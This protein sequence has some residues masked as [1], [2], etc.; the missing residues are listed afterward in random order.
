MKNMKKWMLAAALV[1]GGLGLGATNAQAAR[2]GVYVGGPVA[3]AAPAPGPGYVWVN[4]Y[5]ANGVYVRGYWNRPVVRFGYGYGHG[6]YFYHRDHF[7][8]W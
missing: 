7:R 1:V 2:I 4:G 8:R 3:Y 5:Y 6:P